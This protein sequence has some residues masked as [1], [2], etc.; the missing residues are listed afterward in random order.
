MPEQADGR[1]PNCGEV[2]SSLAMHWYHESCPYPELGSR[3]REILTGL[4]LGDGSIPE[5][6]G[7]HSF[8]LPMINRRFLEWFNEQ[9]EYLTTGVRLVHTAAELAEHNRESGF[10]PTA[11]AKNYHDTYVVRTRA[12]PYFNELRSWYDSGQ[13]RFPDDLALT[14]ERVEVLVR[15]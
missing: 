15:F 12:H 8:R 7:N 2:F 6:P 1:C 4:L 5:V 9:M 10:S 14:P 11:E 3:R 13:K